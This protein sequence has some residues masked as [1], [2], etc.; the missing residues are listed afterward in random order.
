[1]SNDLFLFVIRIKNQSVGI[2]AARV[3]VSWVDGSVAFEH[4]LL[5]VAVSTKC[6]EYGVV[7][8]SRGIGH[9]ECD[10]REVCDGKS[11]GDGDV[12]EV[13]NQTPQAVECAV[14]AKRPVVVRQR[15]EGSFI[16][17]D[18]ELFAQFADKSGVEGKGS[19]QLKLNVVATAMHRD[20][21]DQ[22]GGTEHSA[23]V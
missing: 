17:R 18:P 16:E 1:M 8:V 19:A 6:V 10:I 23:L 3:G 7:Q 21:P 11:W 4:E 20:R 2:E 12:I 9:L 13:S 15:N 22:H 14:R 5:S